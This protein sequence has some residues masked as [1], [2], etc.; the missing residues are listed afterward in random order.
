LGEIETFRDLAREVQLD[1]IFLRRFSQI[2]IS[3]LANSSNKA[4]LKKT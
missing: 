2:R 1:L 3:L 4:S